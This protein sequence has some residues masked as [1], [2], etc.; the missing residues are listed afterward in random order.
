[1]VAL[2]VSAVGLS[3]GDG[4]EKADKWLTCSDE[5]FEAVLDEYL[6]ASRMSLKVKGLSRST[7]PECSTPGDN[8]ALGL[9][10]RALAAQRPALER[11][12][13]PA[14]LPFP[15]SSPLQD[16][17]SSPVWNSTLRK[18][19]P[20]PPDA[21]VSYSPRGTRCVFSDEVP[22]LVCKLSASNPEPAIIN[23]SPQT[24][25]PTP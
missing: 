1:M 14:L 25:K 2:F 7:L 15:P 8:I 18:M 11:P 24:L 12:S 21:D 19:V 10:N 17:V 4:V 13:T 5:S 20:V 6:D 3:L 22:P 9:T 23:P 16:S